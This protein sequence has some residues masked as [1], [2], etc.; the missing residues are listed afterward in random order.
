MPKGDM[1]IERARN[2]QLVWLR[3]LALIAIRRLQ[4]GDKD[5]PLICCPASSMS[6]V[7]NRGPAMVAGPLKRSSS[8]T[9][10]G[11]RLRSALSFAN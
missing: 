9:A 1:T 4:E 6:S 2:I 5:I 11:T 8:S 3:K 10:E 7:A